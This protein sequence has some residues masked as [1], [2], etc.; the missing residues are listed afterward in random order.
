MKFTEVMLP[1]TCCKYYAI[2]SITM[3]GKQLLKF[4]AQICRLSL[5][6]LKLYL[7]HSKKIPEP[8]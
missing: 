7:P 2:L 8:E 4:A 3:L 5:G 1:C 6:T